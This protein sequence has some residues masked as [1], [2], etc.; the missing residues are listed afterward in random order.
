VEVKT[1]MVRVKK[2]IAKHQIWVKTQTMKKKGKS[3]RKMKEAF[4]ATIWPIN[5]SKLTKSLLREELHLI[6][7]HRY[8]VMDDI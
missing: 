3:Q 2:H 4:K 6:R 5:L 1:E 7:K 8:S